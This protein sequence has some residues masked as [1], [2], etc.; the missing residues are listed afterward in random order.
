MSGIAIAGL[1]HLIDSVGVTL[2]MC[3]DLNVY[4]VTAV[5]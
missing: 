4:V 1:D 2:C 5:W 3:T